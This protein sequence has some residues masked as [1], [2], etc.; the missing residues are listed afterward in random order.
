MNNDLNLICKN[1]QDNL[2]N[3]FNSENN[4]PF[5]LKYYLMQ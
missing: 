2:V 3:V 1:F 4:L 5:I